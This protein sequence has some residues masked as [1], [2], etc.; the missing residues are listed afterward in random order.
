M[1][2]GRA[3]R[4]A[5]LSPGH[6]RVSVKPPN[7]SELSRIASELGFSFDSADVEFFRGLLDGALRGYDPLDKL[8]DALPRH[9]CEAKR[10]PAVA[11][12]RA[13]LTIISAFTPLSF[14]A[15]CGVNFA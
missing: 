1:R 3:C 6:I 11:I 7:S 10:L 15:N 13:V 12:S 2:G 4:A 14:S 5:S 9:R 8:P